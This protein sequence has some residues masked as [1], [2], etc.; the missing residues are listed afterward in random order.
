MKLGIFFI[1]VS[2]VLQAKAASVNYRRII[3]G[4]PQSP[5]PPPSHT[6]HSLKK[7]S[8]GSQ[9]PL[10]SRLRPIPIHMPPNFKA[11]IGPPV[12]GR[13]PIPLRTQHTWNSRFPKL[14]TEKPFLSSPTINLREYDYHLQTNSIPH[15]NTIQQNDEKG[16]I[17]TIPAPN[18]SLIDKPDIIGEV[19]AQD[20]LQDSLLTRKHI[21]QQQQLQQD[22]LQQEQ[23]KQ[24]QQTLRHQQLQNNV[25]DIQKLQ[26]YEVTESLPNVKLPLYFAPDP[27]PNSNLRNMESSNQRQPHAEILIGSAE[28]LLNNQLASQDLHNLLNYPQQQLVDTYPLAISQQP[29]LQQHVQ[30]HKKKIYQ[31]LGTSLELPLQ[32]HVAFENKF[33]PTPQLQLFN[34]NEQNHD[35]SINNQINSRI[36]SDYNS[37]PYSEENTGD[38]LAQTQFVQHFFTAHDDNVASNHVEHENDIKDRKSVFFSI[39]PSKEAADT[40]ASLQE[41]GESNNK[42]Q[43]NVKVAQKMPITI[44]VPDNYDE[45]NDENDD[46]SEENRT[47]Y[48]DSS[49]E[50]NNFGKNSSFGSRLRNKN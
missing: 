30:R 29:Q 4:P 2:W 24:F 16:P 10:I 44:Y 6:Q 17:H 48:D 8:P 12:S 32:D 7:W 5:R 49:I 50:E 20:L 33:A 28:H 42:A 14:P 36:G 1:V 27:N 37:K 45:N 22:Q 9:R 41:A 47:N 40:L 18:L 15:S 35:I 39:L 25:V 13:F 38:A 23:L 11:P 19:S 21:L 46:E 3:R 31:G 43:I 26:Q 34:Y